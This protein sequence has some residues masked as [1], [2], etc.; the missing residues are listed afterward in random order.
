MKI[1]DLNKIT[2]EDLKNFDWKSVKGHL[3]DWR[4]IKDHLL[5]N[6]VPVIC[7]LAIAMTTTSI[8]FALR[9]HKNVAETQ[10]T[11][12]KQLRKR[13]EALDSFEKIQK[14]Y[15]EFLAK[16]PQTISENKMIEMLS[17]IALLRKVQIV[18]F[19]PTSKKSND[20]ISLTNVEITI[21]SE[22][23]ADTIRF[24]H[25]IE[26]SPFS[27]RIGSWS[28]VLKMP[29]QV[30]QRLTR[31]SDQQTMDTNDIKNEYIEASINIET[32]EFNNE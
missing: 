1:S 9:V 27:I 21:A 2:F 29:A 28:G 15:S 16:V 10:R 17:E 5:G 22:S 11:E 23:Y 26:N 12:I 31:R 4:S 20:Q 18:S 30:P 24:I 6:P 8:S 13:V 25:D 7:V 19:S 3:S 32:L 14:Q